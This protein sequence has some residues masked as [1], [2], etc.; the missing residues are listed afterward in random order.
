ME[1]EA[2]VRD[3]LKTFPKRLD[4]Y[5]ALLTRN[6][7]VLDRL[8]GI[9]KLTKE[10]ALSYGVTGPILRASGVDWDLRKS[11]SLHG[12]RRVRF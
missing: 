11:P 9:G 7:F 10:K 3:F 6:P 8:L 1:F 4:E 2:A 12:L 5:E